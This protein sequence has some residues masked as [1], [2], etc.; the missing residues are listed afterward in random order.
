[1]M[2]LPQI[3]TASVDAKIDLY[4][5]TLHEGIVTAR[6]LGEVSYDDLARFAALLGTTKIDIYSDVGFPGSECTPATSELMIR[7]RW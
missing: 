4:Q 2:T 7:M 6:I 3:I 5:A 1:M